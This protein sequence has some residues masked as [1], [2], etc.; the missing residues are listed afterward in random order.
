[1]FLFFFFKQKTAYEMVWSESPAPMRMSA[2]MPSGPAMA[3]LLVPCVAAG[4]AE[5]I[6]HVVVILLFGLAIVA[7]AALA[8]RLGLDPAGAR[9]ASLL[10]AA[11]PAAVG[12]AGTA[13]PDVPAMA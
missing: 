12:M 3:Y 11:T 10:L 6:A 4:G 7:T 8:L 5:W 2:I 9:A 1:M 13:M